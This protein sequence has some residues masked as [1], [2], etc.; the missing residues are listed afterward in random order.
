M[1][2]GKRSDR[3]IPWVQLLIE[4]VLVVF[5]VLLALG[6]KSCHDTRAQEELAQQALQNFKREILENQSEITSVFGYHK[7]MLDSLRGENPPTSLSLN[8]P[9]LQNNAWEAAQS[10][11]AISYIDFSIVEIVSKIEE[12]QSE[13]QDF[14]RATLETILDYNFQS[15]LNPDRVSHGLRSIVTGIVNY[16]SKLLSLYDEALKRIETGGISGGRDNISSSQSHK[17]QPGATDTL[18]DH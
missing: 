4:A 3:K 5:S 1:L 15:G 17:Q 10:T 16:E 14:L 11:G 8:S 2:L 9:D 18:S 6:M 13:Y 12:T 7:N